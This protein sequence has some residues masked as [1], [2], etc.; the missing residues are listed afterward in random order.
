MVRLLLMLFAWCFST[1]YALAGKDCEAPLT[2]LL[3]IKPWSHKQQ[4]LVLT[5]TDLLPPDY[6]RQIVSEVGPFKVE[7]THRSQESTLQIEGRIGRETY[8]RVALVA[9]PDNPKSLIVDN[10]D[11]QD[12]L[13]SGK[14]DHL[15]IDQKGKGLP[16]QVFQHIRSKLFEIARAGGFTEIRTTSQ[17]N[18]TVLMLYRRFV[19]MVP[20]DS[21]SQ[22]KIEYLDSLYH[23]ARKELPES[24]RVRN[25]EEFSRILGTGT[26]DPS[27]LGFGSF[28]LF[29][30]IQSLKDYLEKGIKDETFDL[31]VNSKNE[32]IGALFQDKSSDKAESNVVFFDI[33]G[34][35]PQILNWFELA[36]LH[37]IHLV[38]SIEDKSN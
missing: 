26:L 12:P 31:L 35:K 5:P 1:S 38:K 10:L 16:P 29:K 2:R 20:A 33:T 9:D 32:V 14:K 36:A 34:E 8:I 17:Q 7:V 28:I 30:R 6:L 37:K 18:Y 21:E 3:E 27:G 15:N 19:G 23:F 13:K 4:N 25:V 24:E 22:K 11:L